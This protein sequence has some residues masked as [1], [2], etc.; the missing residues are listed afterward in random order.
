MGWCCGSAATEGAP[1]V[2]LKGL[3]FLGSV[4]SLVYDRLALNY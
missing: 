4:P 2:G 3:Q 1:D